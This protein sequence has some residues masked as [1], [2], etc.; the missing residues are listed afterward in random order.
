M[1][2]FTWKNKDTTK[3]ESEAF[4]GILVEKI[5]AFVTKR[6]NP[7]ALTIVGQRW[8]TQNLELKLQFTEYNQCEQLHE[9]CPPEQYS[10]IVPESKIDTILQLVPLKKLAIVRIKAATIKSRTEPNQDKAQFWYKILWKVWVEQ[11][12]D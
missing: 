11:S 6:T 9:T 5:K 12:R 3:C 7:D 8:S 2:N 4:P 10:W 1:A